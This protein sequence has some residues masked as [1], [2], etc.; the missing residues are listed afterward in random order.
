[1]A[2]AT[3]RAR[4]V[5]ED[6]ESVNLLNSPLDLRSVGHVEDY[7]R[8]AIVRVLQWATSFRIHSSR[9]SSECLF[10]EFPADASVGAGDQDCFVFDVHI[11]RRV[12]KLCSSVLTAVIMAA[13]DARIVRVKLS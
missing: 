1:M 2:T 7:G 12:C 4:P 8:D 9:A 5:D 6:V 13:G 3:T 11:V 10:E